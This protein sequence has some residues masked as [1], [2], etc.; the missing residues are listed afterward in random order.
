VEEK[1]NGTERRTT[2]RLH[3]KLSVDYVFISDEQQG[4]M[5]EKCLGSISNISSG[6]A[7]LELA[8]LNE[9]LAEGLT[10][11]IIKVALEIR[12]PVYI[13][14]VKAIAK[15]V[16]LKKREDPGEE[17]RYFLGLSFA[18]ITDEDKGRIK[19]YVIDAYLE[20]WNRDPESG[21]RQ[22]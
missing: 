2:T 6:G 12:I 19:R 3:Q 20:T 15:V 18:D 13:D 21:G 10:A 8:E 11:G 14:P 9:G 7:L 17:K 5:P 22:K 16:W 1:Y 4:A